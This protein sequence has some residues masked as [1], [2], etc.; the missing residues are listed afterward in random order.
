M[1]YFFTACLVCIPR[2]WP[3]VLTPMTDLASLF[4]LVIDVISPLIFSVFP[5][6]VWSVQDPHGE[7]WAAGLAAIPIRPP[8]HHAG[9]DGSRAG[10]GDLRPR[11]PNTPLQGTGR[12]GWWRWGGGRAG[13]MRGA[14]TQA[15]PRPSPGRGAWRHLGWCE[16]ALASLV[17]TVCLLSILG[18]GCPSEHLL[19]TKWFCF[20]ISGARVSASF[21]ILT[22]WV[23][24]V[25]RKSN[26]S[27]G[28]ALSYSILP[29]GA[30]QPCL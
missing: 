17:P 22:S 25:F 20:L 13:L 8:L 26:F 15:A 9:P 24:P 1:L 21:W 12:A 30:S 2:V 29:T 28:S 3:S 16:G 7:H 14:Q 5:P 18:S 27:L 6:T 4:F 10:P 23:L 11:P 19:W